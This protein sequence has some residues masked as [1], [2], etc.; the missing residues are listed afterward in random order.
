VAWKADAR[1]IVI[2]E[3]DILS[4]CIRL[5]SELLQGR[6]KIDFPDKL[7]ILTKRATALLSI[8]S[9]RLGRLEG[10]HRSEEFNRCLLPHA[11]GTIASI[12]KAL[13]FGAAKSRGVPPKLLD[14]YLSYA[15]RSDVG[16]L[17][18]MANTGWK[19]A[20]DLASFEEQAFSNALPD[21]D[22]FLNG[23]KVDGYVKAPIV[24]KKDWA[25][26]YPL[27]RKHSAYGSELCSARLWTFFNWR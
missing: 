6:V 20:D 11:E 23:L 3:G 9:N 19:T 7:S 14:I 17:S 26:Y 2:A 25:N 13:A 4:L 16:C 12:G 21:L 22:G 27:L 18:Q 1:G 15:V 24:N 5:F 8:Y 10:G